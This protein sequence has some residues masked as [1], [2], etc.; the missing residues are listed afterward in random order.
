MRRKGRQLPESSLVYNKQNEVKWRDNRADHN[1]NRETKR[2]KLW[3]LDPGCNNHMTGNKKWFLN[4]EE[5]FSR[6]VKLKN[7]TTMEVV[8][9]GSIRVELN[10]ITQVISDVY[11]VLGLK[12]NLLS[13]GKLQE[14]GIAILIQNG[15][16]KM[17]HPKRDLIMQNDM[18][19]NIMF[20]VLA[21]METKSST[22][23]ETEGVADKKT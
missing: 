16:C 2:E 6:T 19:G 20:Y 7:D 17:F 13:L 12:N 11:Y 22:C 15:V 5:Y 1:E 3:F 21:S 10:G 23:L 9:K 4:L 8:A 14:K 18:S